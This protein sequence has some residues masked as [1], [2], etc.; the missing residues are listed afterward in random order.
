VVTEGLL[1]GEAIVITGHRDLAPGDP[2]LVSRAGVCCSN[3]RAVFG[4]YGVTGGEAA[5]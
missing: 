1:P 2:L 5:P 3:G 4:Q